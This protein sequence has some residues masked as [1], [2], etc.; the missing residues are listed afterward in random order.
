MCAEDAKQMEQN[1]DDEDDND[2]TGGAY[3]DPRVD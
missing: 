2:C 3:S 1:E